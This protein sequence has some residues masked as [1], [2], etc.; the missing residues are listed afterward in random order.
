MDTQRMILPFY[1]QRDRGRRRQKMER[2]EF[3][4]KLLGMPLASSQTPS[5]STI[6]CV[7]CEWGDSENDLV[8][9]KDRRGKSQ[10]S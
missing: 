3:A 2:M 4:L 5:C 1:E 9:L 6:C 7:R 10:P 8:T